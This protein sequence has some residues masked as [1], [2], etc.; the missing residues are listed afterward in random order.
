MT[1]RP[2]ILL[3]DDEPD[4]LVALQ[5]LLEDRY[6]ILAFTSPAEALAR[7]ADEPDLAVIVSD[8]RM[9]EMTGD[10]FLTE[11]RRVSQAEA[12]LLT[13]YADLNAVTAALNS[14]GIVGYAPKP[15]EADSLRAMIAVTT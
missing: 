6:D 14:G 10:A 15:W 8:Q 9:P 13:G 2:L 1:S 12:I 11:A 5:D 3:V 4:I 7:L